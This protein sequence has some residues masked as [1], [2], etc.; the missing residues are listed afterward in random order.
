MTVRFA[1]AWSVWIGVVA[2]IYCFLYVNSPLND[3]G[4]MACTFVSLPMFFMTGAN[5]REII[6]FCSSAAI[7]VLWAL[8]F[9]ALIGLLL[10]AGLP[11]AVATGLGV[12]SATSVLCAF[13]FIVT[14]K[15][16]FTRV[17]MMFGAIAC[18]FF[19]GPDKWLPLMITLC[20]GVLL[21]YLCQFGFY[22]FNPDGSLN[23]SAFKRSP[24]EKAFNGKMK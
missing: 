17:P 10:E 21:A 13:H 1:I 2:G 12:C 24:S 9:I 19:A 7:G 8:G 16:A 18:T 3:S 20:F 22:L 5:K 4:V 11:A 15:Y 23:L 6:D 14:T